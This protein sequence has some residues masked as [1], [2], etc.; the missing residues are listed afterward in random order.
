MKFSG[1]HLIVSRSLLLKDKPDCLITL[2][3]ADKV[4]HHKNAFWKLSCQVQV[5][6]RWCYKQDCLLPFIDQ[7]SLFSVCFYHSQNMFLYK[8]W[9]R[10][11][12]NTKKVFHFNFLSTSNHLPDMIFFGVHFLCFRW[13]F[14]ILTWRLPAISPSCGGFF[15]GWLSLA[16]WVSD[17]YSQFSDK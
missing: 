4:N 6:Q 15:G 3:I 10:K 7:F 2:L 5:S 12:S 17:N 9:K 14:W 11:V 1:R 13:L 8:Q 16:R